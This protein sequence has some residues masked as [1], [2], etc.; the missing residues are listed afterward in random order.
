MKKIWRGSVML[1]GAVL[2]SAGVR[3]Q[4]TGGLTAGVSVGAVRI[5][6]I[7]AAF[8]DV[9]EGKNL[10]GFE[11]GLFMKM[12]AGPV[13]L[14]PMALYNFRKG[15]V[16]YTV[17]GSDGSESTSTFSMHK[18]SV[19]VLL[20]FHLAGPLTIEGGPVFNYLAGITEQ[21]GDRTV[22]VGNSGLGYR[23]GLG[24][25]FEK[26][27]F[28]L[29]YSGSAVYRGGST[30]RASFKEPYQLTFGIGLALGD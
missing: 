20:G 11:G 4:V 6:N 2:L 23:V 24:A 8:T 22:L 5:N 9:I 18:I 12:K 30:G 21:Y 17:N 29:S 15:D 28:H 19:P 16:H 7:D 10:V 26:V 14:R 1:L 27:L 3:A 25:D 13:F